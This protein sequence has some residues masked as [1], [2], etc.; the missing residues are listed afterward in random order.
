MIGYFDNEEAT[1]TAIK[2]GWFYT[3]DLGKW[4]SR[5]IFI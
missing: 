4:I 2:D 5:D 1:K 3:G